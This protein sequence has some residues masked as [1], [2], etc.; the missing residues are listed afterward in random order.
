MVKTEKKLENAM[1]VSQ[2]LDQQIKEE[3]GK[4]VNFNSY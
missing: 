3:E 1:G 4:I 2:K